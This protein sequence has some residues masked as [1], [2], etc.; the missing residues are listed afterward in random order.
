MQVT[1][2]GNSITID[3]FGSHNDLTVESPFELDPA[4]WESE[5]GIS[6]DGWSLLRG[7]FD[8]G[9]PSIDDLVVLTEKGEVQVLDGLLR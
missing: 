4:A 8:E 9:T 6:A 3:R 2:Q 5:L 1:R 7:W